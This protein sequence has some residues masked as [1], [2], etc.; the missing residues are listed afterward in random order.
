MDVVLQ[1]EALVTTQDVIIS[2]PALD[3]VL[4]QSSAAGV[5]YDPTEAAWRTDGI[6]SVEQSNSIWRLH[7][8]HLTQFAVIQA[9]EGTTNDDDSPNL[10]WLWILLAVLLL[11]SILLLFLFCCC[12]KKEKKTPSEPE[13]REVVSEDSFPSYPFD[14]PEKGIEEEKPP[15]KGLEESGEVHVGG[16]GGGGGGMTQGG[17]NL[18]PIDRAFVVETH[19]PSA[20]PDFEPRQ[21]QPLQPPVRQ[22]F[23]PDSGNGKASDT[24]GH[25]ATRSLLP[26]PGVGSMSS[27][28]SSM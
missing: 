11:C 13:Q 19:R 27:Y 6:T 14:R 9:E 10:I 3:T 7:S 2:I 15:R 1:R 22:P 4:P 28:S 23:Q 8:A 25:T 12:R 21:Q 17:A 18:N 16:G 20:D 24:P 5:Y 26:P